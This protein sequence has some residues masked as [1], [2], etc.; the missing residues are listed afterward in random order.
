MERKNQAGSNQS[1]GQPVS[2]GEFPPRFYLVPQDREFFVGR[3]PKK[4]DLVIVS[5]V[6]VSRVHAALRVVPVDGVSI[7]NFPSLVWLDCGVLRQ[8]RRNVIV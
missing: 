2:A 7:Y 1:A 6:T 8:N 3:N 4:A 5:N